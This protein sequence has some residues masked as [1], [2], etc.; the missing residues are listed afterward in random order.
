MRKKIDWHIIGMLTSAALVISA[1]TL[2]ICCILLGDNIFY[3]TSIP[4]YLN[5]VFIMVVAVGV[6]LVTIYDKK[7]GEEIDGRN[8]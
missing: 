1:V 7:Y 8:Y 3:S 6:W 2:A 5:P 4:I